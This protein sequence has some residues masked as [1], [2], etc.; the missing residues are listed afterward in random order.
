VDC[1]LR[2]VVFSTLLVE[3]RSPREVVSTAEGAQRGVTAAGNSYGPPMFWLFDHRDGWPGAEADLYR[4][5]GLDRASASLMF[6]GADMRNLAVK[7]ASYQDLSV[8]ALVTAGAEANA[9]RASRD[10]GPYHEP[11]T[12]NVILLVNRRLNRGG[13]TGLVVVATEAKTAALWDLDYR[14]SQ[15]P[16]NPATGTG[17]DDVIVVWGD[18]GKAIDYTSGHTKTGEL[19]ARVVY[20]GVVEALR[21]Q[22]GK[23]PGRGVWERL[24]ERGVDLRALGPAFA[25]EGPGPR[26]APKV[27]RLL[28]D[29]ETA[30]FMEAAMSLSDARRL[31]HLSDAGPF[32]H[33][34]LAEASRVAGRPVTEIGSLVTDAS[35]PPV[36]RTALDALAAGL[37]ARE[38]SPP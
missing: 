12:I 32:R 21:L 19:A 26:L 25:P 33:M 16:E 38:G 18:E 37:L 27:R 23:A 7:S 35:V 2:D 11:G 31:G 34:A 4:I 36:L 20:D 13:A 9:L 15:N 1:R 24:A 6:T 5:L 14:S 10:S 3:F 29:P 30:A 8:T 28:L 22:N 17:T